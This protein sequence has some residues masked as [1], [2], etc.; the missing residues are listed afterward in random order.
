M[1]SSTSFIDI[2]FEQSQKQGFKQYKLT[3]ISEYGLIDEIKTA[4]VYNTEEFKK[5]TSI[6]I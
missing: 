2:Q 3:T 1:Q 6:S 5:D 4:K